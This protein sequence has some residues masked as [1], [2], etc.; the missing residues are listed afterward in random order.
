VATDASGALGVFRSL[1]AY[2]ITMFAAGLFVF[3]ALLAIHG[4]AAQLFSY[5]LFLRASAF[6]QLATFFAVLGIFF[7]TPAPTKS[8]LLAWLPSY[9]F[10]GLFQ[11]LNGGPVNP[12]FGRLAARAAASLTIAGAAAL[13]FYTL[14]YYRHVRRALEEPDIAPGGRSHLLSRVSKWISQPL[15]RAIFLFTVR[16]LTRS[17]QHRLLLAV[18]GAIGLAFA[19]AYGK[20]GWRGRWDHPNVPFLAATLILLFFSIVGV[21]AIFI[22]PFELRANWIFHITAVHSPNAYFTA[23]RKSLLWLAAA[24]PLACITLLLSAVWPWRPV[25]EHLGICLAMAFLLVDLFLYRF[26][27]IPFTCSYLPGGANLKVKLGAYG[28]AFLCLADGGTLLE[29]WAFKRPARF[30]TLLALLVAAAIWA[31][32]RRSEFAAAAYTPLQFEDL[33]P[34][35]IFALDFRRDSDLTGSEQY[36]D[37]WPT[38]PPADSP[39]RIAPTRARRY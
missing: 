38:S 8:N 5:R 4:L 12:V 31:H 11:E 6:L 13:M 7:L 21:R 9:W 18:Y 27:K 34:A 22:L 20:S 33:P 10:L 16:T 1:G 15:E 19:L 3:C 25:L 32:R 14:A 37:T 39:S 36:I 24:P 26:R 17:R 2:W 35:E 28:I 29:F 23:I 30:L